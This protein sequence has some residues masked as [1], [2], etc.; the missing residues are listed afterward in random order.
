MKIVVFGA[1]YC[2]YCVN[3]KKLLE[4]HGKQFT[5]IDT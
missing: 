3:A 5:W 2:P 1:D 4:K